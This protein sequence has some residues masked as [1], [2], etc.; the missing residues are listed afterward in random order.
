MKTD[1]FEKSKWL[2]IYGAVVATRSCELTNNSNLMLPITE[3]MTLIMDEAKAVA[4]LEARVSREVFEDEPWDEGH[5]F[6]DERDYSCP[7]GEPDCT[8]PK[9]VGCDTCGGADCLCPYVK[10][11]REFSDE[12]T[13][14]G[15]ECGGCRQREAIETPGKP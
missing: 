7:C 15:C 6:G 3:A 12:E 8:M 5:P 13:L 9:G 4:D 10:G 11:S 14:P 1:G 2:A